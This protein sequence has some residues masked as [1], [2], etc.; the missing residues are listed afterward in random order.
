MKYQWLNK[1]ILY[2]LWYV[3]WDIVKE[4]SMWLK[5]PIVLCYSQ[6]TDCN[7]W[8]GVE[9]KHSLSSHDDEH[10]LHERN[11]DAAE[12]AWGLWLNGFLQRLLIGCEVWVHDMLHVKG[13]QKKEV[14]LRPF[15]FGFKL[16]ILISSVHGLYFLIAPG[17]QDLDQ[18][19]FICPSPLLKWRAQKAVSQK[20]KK[21]KKNKNTITQLG[22]RV[23]VNCASTYV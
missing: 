18:S 15:F 22:K 14:I 12:E 16:T 21:K 19:M 3:I 8:V 5:Q 4:N 10:Y 13:F 7:Q 11:K 20:Q 2:F 17:D 23:C 1:N 9:I 6:Q